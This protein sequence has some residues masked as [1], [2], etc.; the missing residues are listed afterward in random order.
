[1]WKGYVRETD[2]TPNPLI[3]DDSL[4]LWKTVVGTKLL[5]KTAS[6]RIRKGTSGKGKVRAGDESGEGGSHGTTTAGAKN[7]FGIA[8][9]AGAPEAPEAAEAAGEAAAE[10]RSTSVTANGTLRRRVGRGTS[11]FDS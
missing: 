1:M 10:E 11:S 3:D 9:A 7:G 8:A 4:D 5:G 6:G 2:F